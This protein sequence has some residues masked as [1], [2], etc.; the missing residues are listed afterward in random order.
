MPQS[1]DIVLDGTPYM[2]APGSYRRASAGF[3]EGRTGR[4]AISDF[5]GGQRRAMQ[6]ERDTSWDSPGVGPALFGQGVAPWPFGL[7]HTDGNVIP[8][9]AGQRVHALT[10]DNAVYLGIGRYVYRTVALNAGSWANLTQVADLGAGQ[11]VSGLAYYGGFLAI[12]CGNGADLQLLD[13]GSL[14]LTTLSP[15]LRGGWIAGY[16]GHLVLSDPIPGNEAILRLTT[17]GGLDTRELDAPITTMALHG[18]K[19]AIAT[20]SALWLLGG[21]GEA[22]N[23]VWLGEPEPVYTQYAPD[24]DDFRF[25]CSFG[26]KLYTWLGGNAVEWNPNSGASRQGWRATG[27]DG[28]ACFGGTVAGNM[29]VVA[30]ESH[31]GRFQLWAFDGTGWWLM[32][33][34]EE[35]AWVWPTALVGA[36]SFDLLAIRDGESGV[37]YDLFRMTGRGPAA[38]A[39]A[40]SGQFTT[41]L[42]DAGERGAEK[43][44]R[45]IGAVFAVPEVRG[46]PASTDSVTLTL[47]W[48]IDCGATWT[49]AA[50]AHISDPDERVIELGGVLPNGGAVAPFL[51]IRVG[52]DSVVDWS[53]VLTGIWADYAVLDAPLRRR[54][55]TFSIIARD[56]TVQ[57]DGSVAM[58]DGHAQIA[59]LWQSWE[60]HQTLSLRDL[61]Y[62]ANPVE[63]QVRI[64]AIEESVPKPADAGAWGASLVQLQ[65][66][67]L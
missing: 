44:W 3:P 50:T 41:S 7:A 25:L 8:V 20:R 5:V 47:E 2:L 61:D 34:S 14:A 54:R 30:T 36:G 19:V 52:F 33:E 38:P 12:G 58:L 40:A 42:L 67:E 63:R 9:S 62:D 31:A 17:G 64:L 21:R 32:R 22:L 37:I 49:V 51:Q 27:L 13:P 43:S 35:R 16:A 1:S 18:G 59:A 10:L 29:L 28:R 23:G 55:W 53:P 26:G 11:V 15:G 39:L 6:L 57:R 65:L 60:E 24:T 45:G 4:V 46:N 48:S 56:G 66:L